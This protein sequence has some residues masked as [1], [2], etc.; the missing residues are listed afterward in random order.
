MNTF[1]TTSLVF[2]IKC[3]LSG[4]IYGQYNGLKRRKNTFHLQEF[5][6]CF[7]LNYLTPFVG[8]TSIL[9][10]LGSLRPG[11]HRVIYHVSEFFLF[12]AFSGAFETTV[13]EK[14]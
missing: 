12:V 2:F 7:W 3:L 10:S 6:L 9:R 11:V 8:K 14:Q 4:T 1:L 13:H 5:V